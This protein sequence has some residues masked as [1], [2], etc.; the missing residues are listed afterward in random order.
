MP[1]IKGTPESSIATVSADSAAGFKRMLSQKDA[2]Q[3]E[4][5]LTQKP[6][7]VVVPANVDLDM[8]C[9]NSSLLDILF[10]AKLQMKGMEYIIYNYRH[11]FYNAWHLISLISINPITFVPSKASHFRDLE[12]PRQVSSLPGNKQKGPKL[13]GRMLSRMWS[14][15]SSMQR[16][17]WNVATSEVASVYSIDSQQGNLHH[18]QNLHEVS[19]SVLLL[20]E[21][22]E[23]IRY[24]HLQNSCFGILLR[25][26]TTWRRIFDISM[27]LQY[28]N[29]RTFRTEY[30]IYI[31]M[32]SKKQ[33]MGKSRNELIDKNI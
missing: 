21:P 27:F 1:Q 6:P 18:N 17:V 4:T 23:K 32:L 26:Y 12:V 19:T 5:W 33:S 2:Q 8:L 14:F 9:W 30:Q 11:Q 3:I 13:I 7:D 16:D 25:E 15:L 10:R 28:I 24:L 29:I 31:Y 22:H 20:S